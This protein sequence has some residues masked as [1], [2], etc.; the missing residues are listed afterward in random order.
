M[1][2][3][4][5]TYFLWIVLFPLLC[6]IFLNITRHFPTFVNNKKAN[7]IRVAPEMIGFSKKGVD[8]LE[9]HISHPVL[10]CLVRLRRIDIGILVFFIPLP[11]NI[12]ASGVLP[13]LFPLIT[14][15]L[16]FILDFISGGMPLRGAF[17]LQLTYPIA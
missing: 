1:R 6:Q 16:E 17:S 11:A 14:Q 10:S 2:N 3:I 8:D 9:S 5:K 13:S 7:E 15:C 12:T 4:S